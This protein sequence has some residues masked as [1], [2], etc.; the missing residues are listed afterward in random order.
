MQLSETEPRPASR[1][2]C[3]DFF[4]RP[5]IEVARSLLGC[6][7]WSETSDGLTG[8]VIVE[9]EAYLAHGD[10]S[11][12][13][14]R[15]Q[16]NRNRPMFGPWGLAYV[17]QIHRSVC[18]N[19]VT[20]PVGVPEAVLIRALQ[21]TAG[22]A[23]IRQRRSHRPHRQLCSGPGKLCQALG[24]TLAHN[25]TD[26]T[27]PPLWFTAEA[28]WPAATPLSPDETARPKTARPDDTTERGLITD[29]QGPQHSNCPAPSSGQ[30]ARRR[31]EQ[32]NSTAG[33]IG[34]LSP[35]QRSDD[36]LVIVTTTRIGLHPDRGADLPLRFYIADNPHI[37]KP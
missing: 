28:D 34:S 2:L 24:V 26:L 5:T 4:N 30:S 7:L 16:T 31:Q 35:V 29:P 11:C 22:M 36:K 19:A 32:T 25:Q 3:R 18:L 14:A 15:G 33:A 23:L 6:W 27:A 13:A 21:P 20:G 8:G 10:P 12:H 37:S 1:P 17:H 9:T